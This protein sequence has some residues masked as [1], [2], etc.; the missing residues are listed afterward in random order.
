MTLDPE[1]A[2][3]RCQCRGQCGAHAGKRCPTFKGQS[4]L[5][6]GPVE[7]LYEV[8]VLKRGKPTKPIHVRYICGAC[9]KTYDHWRGEVDRR[10]AA[11]ATHDHYLATLFRSQP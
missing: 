1:R 4:E 11:T 5:F 7:K 9:K 6:G 3:G 10:A 2:N 8:S